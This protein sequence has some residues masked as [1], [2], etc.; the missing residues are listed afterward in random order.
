[1]IVVLIFSSSFFFECVLWQHTFPTK[2]KHVYTNFF[3]LFLFFV[4]TPFYHTYIG[5]KDVSAEKREPF[6][7]EAR[8]LKTKYD[9]DMETYNRDKTQRTHLHR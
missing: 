4:T 1:M 5:W 9:T 8:L 3:F 6:E 2:S 7:K